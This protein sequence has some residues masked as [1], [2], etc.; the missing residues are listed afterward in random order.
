MGVQ[1]RRVMV[2]IRDGSRGDQ[3]CAEESGEG[4]V[5]KGA[6]ADPGVRGADRHRQSSAAKHSAGASSNKWRVM[7]KRE[8]PKREMP[9]RSSSTVPP[10]VTVFIHMQ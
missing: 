6:Q 7:R 9:K 2:S 3:T 4:L 5:I 8:V 10:S 1:K